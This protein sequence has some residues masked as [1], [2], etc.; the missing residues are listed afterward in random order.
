MYKNKIVRILISIFVFTLFLN[1]DLIVSQNSIYQSFTEN[2]NEKILPPPILPNMILEEAIFMRKS[3]RVFSENEVTDEELSTIL[4]AAY[5]FRSDG[6][7]TVHP[8]DGVY[9]AVIYVFN[10]SGVY[11]Y[12]PINHSLILYKE[13]DMRDKIDIL[14]YNA[15]IQ[16][17]LCW[18]STKADPNLGGAELGQ[19]GQNI[20]FM[21]VALG[22][23]TVVTGQSP[24]AIA[25]VGLPKNEEGLILMPLGHPKDDYDFTYRPLWFSFLPKIKHSKITVSDAINQRLNGTEFLGKLTR[26]ELSQIIWSSYGFSYYIDNILGPSNLVLRHR[27][28]PSAHGYYP[29]CMYIC[30]ESGVYK[31]IG[32]LPNC[33]LWGLPIFSFLLRL[34]AEDVRQ[35][36]AQA[37]NKSEISTASMF[38]VSILDLEATR[39]WDDLSNESLWRF[40]Y[41]EAGASAHNVQ[42]EATA[43]NLSS[44]ILVPKDVSLIRSS[45]NLDNRYFPLLVV[46]VGKN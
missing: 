39:K 17:G 40:W 31:Y 2:S 13:G 26:Q 33:D 22:L 38:I 7:R 44:T 16:L 19:V 25:P 24:A 45:L 35:S 43:W 6:R 42:L 10:E 29:L 20:H 11:R 27:T 14:Q 37:C 32:G 46:P 30:I 34:N 28:V 4:W 8:I 41:Y 9:A 23:G 21:A 12:N 1:V 3:V 18:D 36:I 15:P 5:G